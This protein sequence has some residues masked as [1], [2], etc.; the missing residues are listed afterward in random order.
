LIRTALIADRQIILGA[1]KDGTLR[2]VLLAGWRNT[3]PKPF[4]R[5]PPDE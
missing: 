3:A 5:P 4:A 1:V 2:R